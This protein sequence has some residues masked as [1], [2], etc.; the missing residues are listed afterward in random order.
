MSS[1]RENVELYTQRVDK[2]CTW[3]NNTLFLTRQR[4]YHTNTGNVL[5]HHPNSWKTVEEVGA[6][7]GIVVV[8]IIGGP[9][10]GCMDCSFEE[11]G[12]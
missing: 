11:R 8:V 10:S 7:S 12:S 5:A 3:R 1:S 4:E 2:P 6:S 9:T